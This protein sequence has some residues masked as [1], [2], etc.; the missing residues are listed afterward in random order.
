MD[1]ER[2]H[3]LQSLPALPLIAAAGTAHAATTDL[4][5]TCD[6]ALGPAM[7]AAS[8]RFRHASHV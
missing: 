7:N 5:L 4:V 6:T 8:E 2:R 3:S 1:I